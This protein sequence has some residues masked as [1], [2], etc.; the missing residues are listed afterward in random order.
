MKFQCRTVLQRLLVCFLATNSLAISIEADE[1]EDHFERYVRPLFIQRC[2]KCH[3]GDEKEGGLRLD[4]LQ[5]ILLGGDSGSALIVGRPDQSLL[6]QA[7]RHENGLEMPPDG[8]LAKKQIEDLTKWIADG[9]VWPG[10]SPDTP[11][12]EPENFQ[13]M[14]RLPNSGDL[15]HSLQ[16]WLRADALTLDDGADVSIW[17]DQSPHGR[18][19]AATKGIRAGGVGGPAKLILGSEVNSRPAIRFT[20]QTG[21]AASPGNPVDIHGNAALS[22]TLVMNI[23][24]YEGMPPYSSIFCVGDPAH[25]G[26]PGKPLA[27]LIEL[28]QRQQSSLDFAGGWDHDAS[29]GVGSFKTFF[30]K[31][32]VVTFIKTPGPMNES[33]RI[34]ING[35]LAGPTE[36]KALAGQ[37]TVPDIQH[38]T[39]I[40]LYLGKALSWCGAFEGD[41]AEVL[42]YNTALENEVRLGVELHL[43][44]KY[45]I[46]I[47]D[48][49]NVAEK[50]VYSDDEKSHWAYQPVMEATPPVVENRAWVKNPI[51]QF[52][53]SAFTASGIEPQSSLDKRRL[54]RRV[55]LDLTGLPPTA[56]EVEAFLADDSEQAYLTVVERLLSSHHYGERWGRHWLDL[57]RYAETTA[58]DANAVMRY[59]WRYRNYVIDAFNRDL[60]YDQFLVEQ[61]AGDL[62]PPSDSIEENTRRIIATGFLMIGT[63]ALAETDKEQSRLD[64]VDD[65]IDVTS[66]AMLGMTVACAR[67]HDHKF[68]AIRTTDYYAMAGIFRSTEPFKNENR[69]ATMWWEYAVPQGDKAEPLMVMAPKEAQARNLRVHIRGNRFTLGQTV[70]RGV[71]GVVGAAHPESKQEALDARQQTSGRLELAQWIASPDNPLTTRVLVNRVWQ[72]HFGTGL[73]TTPDNFGI[74]GGRPTQPELLDWLTRQFIDGGWSLKNLHRLIVLSNTYQQQQSESLLPEALQPLSVQRYRLSAEQLRDGILAVSGELIDDPDNSE[75]GEFLFGSAEDINA[76]IRPNRVAADDEFY[77]TFRKRSVYLPIVRNMLPDVLALFDAADP[78]GVTA[79]RNETTVASQSLFLL[80]HPFVRKQAESFAR[81][82]LDAEGLSSE[83]RVDLAHQSAFGRVATASEQEETLAFIRAFVKSP[84]IGEKPESEKRLAAWQAFCQSLFCSNEFLY[85]D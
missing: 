34:Y 7:V 27:A 3:S 42:L 20:S 31:S 51:D 67:C 73:V 72:L 70:Y 13:V 47:D 71:P 69:N 9:A 40:G 17:P 24:Q 45:G 60:P 11:V 68:D 85:V 36:G 28:D 78:N 4:S 23:K 64:I 58:N 48:E 83:Q 84:L 8:K 61:L 33:T 22:I 25:M 50:A 76:E 29:L 35:R 19:V 52:A 14:A 16:L 43:G 38:R 15:S 62:M 79:I 81:L 10:G 53:L 39:D 30:G 80:N 77:T 18:D 49:R 75:S 2:Y 21:L 74:R 32:I 1:K 26:N 12:D 6:L 63:K 56:K 82:I 5:G 41:I 57:V 46:W 65:Q 59:A 54:L 44:E 66:R 37:K 55:T